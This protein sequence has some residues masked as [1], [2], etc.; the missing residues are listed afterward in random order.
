MV[1]DDDPKTHTHTHTQT[2]TLTRTGHPPTLLLTH[3]LSLSPFASTYPSFHASEFNLEHVNTDFPYKVSGV[4]TAFLTNNAHAKGIVDVW[5]V[6][7]DSSKPVLSKRRSQWSL[8]NK[9]NPLH[10]ELLRFAPRTST[11]TRLID[12]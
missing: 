4:D 5:K 11:K 10:A 3:P 6:G 1:V 8:G 2:H 7:F 9:P 12:G